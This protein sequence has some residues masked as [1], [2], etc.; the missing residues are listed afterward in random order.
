MPCEILI[1]DEVAADA[2]DDANLVV[3]VCGGRRI[4]NQIA[5]QNRLTD[6]Q[7]RQIYFSIGWK[8]NPSASCPIGDSLHIDGLHRPGSWLQVPLEVRRDY[9]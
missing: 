3:R 1:C 9:L 5:V 8:L 6:W 7:R 2:D 4:A